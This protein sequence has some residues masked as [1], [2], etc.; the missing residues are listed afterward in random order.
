MLVS[1]RLEGGVSFLDLRQW[2][3]KLSEDCQLA[4]DMDFL[5]DLRRVKLNLLLS[6]VKQLVQVNLACNGRWAFL[7]ETPMETALAKSYET[8]AAGRQEVGVFSTVTAA[9]DFLGKELRVSLLTPF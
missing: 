5:I 3:E 6:D 1:V 4:A 2:L 9:M 8:N 7:V